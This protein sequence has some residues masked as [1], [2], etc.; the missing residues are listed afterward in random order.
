LSSRWDTLAERLRQ[1]GYETIALVENP[2]V[3]S[4]NGF[5]QG[6]A[7]FGELWRRP[8]SEVGVLPLVRIFLAE[9]PTH[10]KP[11]FVF[12]NINIS[13]HPYDDAEEFTGLFLDDS[14]DRYAQAHAADFFLGRVSFTDE[15]FDRIASRYDEELRAADAVIAGMVETLKATDR[16]DSSMFIV[17]SD[18]GEHFG[19]HGLVQHRFSLYQSV[20]RVPL[21]VHYPR[22]YPPGTRV[23]TA[24]QLTDLL[25]TVARA[26]RLDIEDGSFHGETLPWKERK[27]GRPLA[28]RWLPAVRLVA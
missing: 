12:V 24:V 2:V 18:H 23:S 21:L 5:D 14:G 7:R 4:E 19:E 25:P 9:I 28:A 15:E 20:V 1:A 3:S 10:E 11:L 6:F 17:T 16:W 13:H 22:R 26:A 27:E 8:W